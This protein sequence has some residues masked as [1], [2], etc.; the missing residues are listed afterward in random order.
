MK[1]KFAFA[2]FVIILMLSCRAKCTH[3]K[4]ARSDTFAFPDDVET[5]ASS[6]STVKTTVK[7][8]DR[9]GGLPSPTPTPDKFVF[10]TES[11]TPEATTVQ[12]DDRFLLDGGEH[13][14]EGYLYI[15]GKGCR[16]VRRS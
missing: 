16:K 12:V 5:I 8:A 4:F 10:P 2:T 1:Y 11:S 13:C 9:I 14:Q 3:N 15:K 6:S 7:I